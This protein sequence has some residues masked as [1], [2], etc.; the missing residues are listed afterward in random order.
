MMLAPFRT[1]AVIRDP[2]FDLLVVDVAGSVKSRDSAG[3]PIAWLYRHH[4]I[5]LNPLGG[6]GPPL[7]TQRG[8]FTTFGD[9]PF[10]FSEIFDLA[11]FV[12]PSLSG[13]PINIEVFLEAAA[14]DAAGQP[15]A[16]AWVFIGQARHDNAFVLSTAQGGG[17]K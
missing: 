12:H 14:S 16:G 3:G 7:A 8:D 1:H 17:E 11:P 15:I 10:R 13:L 2:S 5:L 9:A 6:F 4:T